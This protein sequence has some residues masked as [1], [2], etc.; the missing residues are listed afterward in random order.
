MQKRVRDTFYFIL[1]R[2]LLVSTK[3]I[4]EYYFD[5]VI[6]SETSRFSLLDYNQFDNNAFI[7]LEM[8][9]AIIA[10]TTTN[11]M[12]EDIYNNMYQL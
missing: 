7:L 11:I 3:I 12:I 10:I 6:N 9:I 1:S 5:P 8:Y 4:G 2:D